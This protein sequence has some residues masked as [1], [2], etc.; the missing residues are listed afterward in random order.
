MVKQHLAEIGLPIDTEKMKTH[1]KC[2]RKHLTFRVRR[3]GELLDK[4]NKKGNKT[5]DI[6]TPQG[7]P[8]GQHASPRAMQQA[9]SGNRGRQGQTQAKKL[10]Q[11][12]Y[13][14]LQDDLLEL[15]GYNRKYKS[16]Q[17]LRWLDQSNN[18]ELSTDEFCTAIDVFTQKWRKKLDGIRRC[19]S[20][21]RRRELKEDLQKVMDVVVEITVLRLMG[22]DMVENEGREYEDHAKVIAAFGAY[23]TML[24]KVFHNQFNSCGYAEYHDPYP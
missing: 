15:E 10:V 3:N 6:A 2:T 17:R 14:K 18:R 20:C 4:R 9:T 13:H 11:K 24:D 12:E 8:T 1:L 22:M 23:A 19:K 5:V 16:N 21:E 7:L